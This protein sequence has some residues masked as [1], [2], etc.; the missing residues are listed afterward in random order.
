VLRHCTTCKQDIEASDWNRHSASHRRN[1]KGANRSQKQAAKQR[2][3]FACQ[4]CG[5]ADLE[6][7]VHHRDG[8]WRNNSAANLAALCPVCHVQADA[9]IK[10]RG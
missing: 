10:A 8:N 9:E 4:D 5:R 3:G 6:L 1:G 7:E 2:A